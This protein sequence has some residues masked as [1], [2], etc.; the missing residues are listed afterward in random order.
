MENNRAVLT[1]SQEELRFYAELAN[2]PEEVLASKQ[3]RYQV[4]AQGESNKNLAEGLDQ[5]GYDEYCQ[6]L[7]V[8]QDETGDIVASMRLLTDDKASLIGSFYSE[9]RFVLNA[10]LPLS[11]KVL[12]I[13]RICIHPAYRNRGAIA[14]LWSGLASFMARHKTDYLLICLNLDVGEKTALVK[15]I[16]KQ[17]RFM[18]MES[19][20]CRVTPR[21]PFNGPATEGIHA[22]LPPML[23]ACLKLGAKVCGEPC[24]D[25]DLNSAELFLL[26]DLG[27][28][29]LDF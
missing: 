5:D 22:L 9:N 24:W 12:E 29:N 20:T 18:S 19:S 8:K 14:A 26:L 16:M 13:S 23:Q 21:V 4:L 7:L 15:A 1:G 25:A 17:I 2:S 28:S 11:G 10:L 3:F 6:H 27:E